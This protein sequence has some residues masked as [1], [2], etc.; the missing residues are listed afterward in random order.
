MMTPMKALQIT[1]VHESQLITLDRPEPGPNEVLIKV[2]ASGICGTDIHILEGGFVADYPVIPGHEFAG[3]V[4]Q[5]GTAVSRIQ[6]GDHV[7]VEPNIACDNCSYCLNNQQ[8]FCENWQAIG[9]TLPGGMAEYVV[10]PE[11]AVFPIGDL[12]FEEGAFV[13]PLSCVLHGVQKARLRLADH[14][15]IM[16][17][18]PIGNL[19]FQT[20]KV[21]GARSV[22]VVEPDPARADF[23][24]EAGADQI[25]S[26]LDDLPGEA[27]EVVIDATGVIP[28]MMRT[29]EFARKGGTILLFGVP[30]KTK[31]E[32]EAFTLFIKGLTILTSF[33][34]V[35]NSIQAIELLKNRHI[36]VKRLVSHRLPLAEFEQGVNLIK[37]KRENVKKILIIPSYS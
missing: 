33:T 26:S 35:R 6:T 7:A 36:N 28:V 3:I 37:N 5:V 10:A 21:Q 24:K 22:T 13:E 20:V 12:E 23:A 9:V 17:A 8:N 4:E 18:G 11:N 32:F 16:G 31:V 29:P 1:K 14:V 34:S 15:V 27:F 2:M 25:C 30:P 19:L